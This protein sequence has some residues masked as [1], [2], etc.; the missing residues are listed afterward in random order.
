MVFKR[1]SL[2]IISQTVLIV[3]TIL[4]FV[5]FINQ[6]GFHAATLLTC[7]I[8]VVLFSKL[9]QFVKKTNAELTR[10]LDAAR[11]ADF[12]QRFNLNNLGSG[13]DELGTV[14]D[15]VLHRLQR[16]RASNEEKLRHLKAIVEHVPVPLMSLHTNQKITLWNHAA[17][18][19]FGN[20]EVS[21]LS[22]LAKFRAE[23]PSEI[24]QVNVGENK[25][26]DIEIDGMNHRLNISTAKLTV[27]QSH[28]TLF[29]MQDIQN[30]LDNVQLQAWQELVKVLTHEIMNSITPVASL[31][32]TA[33]DL[34]Q[35]IQLKNSHSNAILEELED[36]SGAVNT[37]AKRSEGLMSFV[38]SYRKLT[39]LPLPHLKPV[40]VDELLNG[41]IRVATQAW[42][43]KG[44]QLSVNITPPTLEV[45]VDFNMIEQ[46][47]INLLQNA[48]HAVIAAENPR[49]EINAYL[50]PRGRTVI[51]IV[52][53]GCGIADDILDKIFVPFFTTKQHGSGVG[54]AL[55]RQIML[56]HN[57]K[58]KAINN[59]G[60][61]SKFSLLL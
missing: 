57:G 30:E 54:L 9:I 12:S 40:A 22:D 60:N 10:F 49:I 44:I 52:D 47:L 2:F 43:Q 31:A 48:E 19:F 39:H 29:S 42:N 23:L 58:I 20:N 55:S 26:I 38:G 50:N 13:F 46:V 61:G 51:E 37:V 17:R 28:E 41:V 56:A 32:H 35:D 21:K 25:L 24:T 18:R 33:A 15:E 59:V 36:V 27:N 3:L 7:I 34:V 16:E 4:L 14:F 11:H 1:F 45:L 53:N 6:P 5:Y 8:I